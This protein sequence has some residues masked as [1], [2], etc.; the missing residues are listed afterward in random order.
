[1]DLPAMLFPGWQR[2]PHGQA[3]LENA[4]M[5]ERTEELAKSPYP[6]HEQV[7]SHF[8]E[9]K[10]VLMHPRI[11]GYIQNEWHLADWEPQH[12]YNLMQNGAVGTHWQDAPGALIL[13]KESG[14]NVGHLG[15]VSC[16][17][18]T[19][20]QVTFLD[21]EG[22]GERCMHNHAVVVDPTGRD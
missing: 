10:G 21:N 1:M 9:L 19:C 2:L 15:I 16:K 8:P 3:M 13:V 18:A 17:G 20:Y 22:F 14:Q 11:R 12:V 7:W 6:T 5:E 4:A